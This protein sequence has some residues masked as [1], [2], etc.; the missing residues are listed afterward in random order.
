[1]AYNIASLRAGGAV[2]PAVW[3]STPKAGGGGIWM[4]SQ[5]VAID[6]S[7][8]G[9][10]IYFATGNGPYAPSFGADDL[11]ESVVRLHF[12]PSA[13]TLNVVDWFTPFTDAS[14]DVDHQDQD[15]G[16]A[17]VLLIPNS[18]SVLAG[19]K[20]GIF[21]NVD[22]ASMGKLTHTSLLQPDFVGT[23]TPVAPFNYLANTNQAT[24]TDGVTGASGGDR[25]FLPHPADG[26]RTRHFHGGP[27]Y[28]E[29]GSQRLVWV[30]GENSTLRAFRYNGT[31]LTTTP[32][33]ESV[34]ARR[35]RS[36]RRRRA[37]CLAVSW[38]C[39]RPTPR[40]PAASSGRWRRESRCGG[41]PRPMRFPGRASCARSTRP[42]PAR[43]SPS[44]GTA[45][46]TWPTPS[47]PRRSFQ[48]PLVANGRVYVATYNN[49]SS[50]M[51]TP[52]P[53]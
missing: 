53:A 11:G 1:V 28:Y 30:M 44:C 15:L 52:P 23:F 13:N 14:H 5:G 17:G 29:N 38:P 31:A 8:P 25:T 22:R 33:A 24:T 39:H 6:E 32:I 18:R 35:R 36:T 40:A 27:V 41:I 34:R 3:C 9:R 51:P 20:E 49:R 10:D 42:C 46:W 19:G 12:D 7:D 47:G 26:G 2:T 45:K 4:A 50:S 16:S 21:Y 43:R 48:P 37:A